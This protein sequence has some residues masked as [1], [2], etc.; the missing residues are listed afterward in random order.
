MLQC[1]V[2]QCNVV[3]LS[4]LIIVKYHEHKFITYFIYMNDNGCSAENE[5][6]RT[7]TI[8][9]LTWNEE[10]GTT[11]NTATSQC[12]NASD[13]VTPKREIILKPK[14]KL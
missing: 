2:M 12:S 10:K 5:I 8:P 4:F 6:N 13:I 9:S 11:Q 3:F 1:N 7:S 14:V